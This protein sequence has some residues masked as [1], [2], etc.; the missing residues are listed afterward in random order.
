MRNLKHLDPWRVPLYGSYGDG[1]NGAFLLAI[2]GYDY[3]I[4]ASNGGGWEHVSVS[5]SDLKR[6][7]GWDV[8]CKIKDM[9]FEDDEVVIQIHPAKKDYINNHPYCLHLWRS[10]EAI[11]PLPP[12]EFI[13]LKELNI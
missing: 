1:Q 4:I 10:T 6:P 7:P 3:K 2:A 12:P 11:Q 13:G 5:P 9:F 8:M